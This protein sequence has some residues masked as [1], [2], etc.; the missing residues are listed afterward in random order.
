MIID[1]KRKFKQSFLQSSSSNHKVGLYSP[2]R[3]K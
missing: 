3:F 1:R 2:Q